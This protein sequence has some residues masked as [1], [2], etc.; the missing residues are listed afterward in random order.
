MVMLTGALFGRALGERLRGVRQYGALLALR[1]VVALGRDAHS[2]HLLHGWRHASDGRRQA[3]LA[4]HRTDALLGA[5]AQQNL[6]RTGQTGPVLRLSIIVC[7]RKQQYTTD[8]Q[9]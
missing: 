5:A 8:D 6:L 9:E 1:H 2:Q 7:T 3:L 4:R